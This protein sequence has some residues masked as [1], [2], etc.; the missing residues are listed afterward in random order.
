[1]ITSWPAPL[2][3]CPKR[4][5]VCTSSSMNRILAILP[6]A[7]RQSV[8]LIRRAAGSGQVVNRNRVGVQLASSLRHAL[9]GLI[10][11]ERLCLLG[12]EAN[13]IDPRDDEA[14]EVRAGEATGLQ[15]LHLLDDQIVQ[16]QDGFGP[17]LAGL[18]RSAQGAFDELIHALEHRMVGAA[19]EPRPLLVA[20][21]QRDEGRLLELQRLL[22]QI[23]RLL[24]VQRKN[25]I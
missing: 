11:R 22:S 24:G 21:A 17:R 1:M 2:R 23:V 6:S 4:S 5:K 7:L 25:L 16:R 14:L 15:R 18:Q 8:S 20:E 12:S 10:E 19:A 3:I 13:R 9:E